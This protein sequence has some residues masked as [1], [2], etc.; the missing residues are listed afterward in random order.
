MEGVRIR[1]KEIEERHCKVGLAAAAAGFG[2][3]AMLF[4]CR[5]VSQHDR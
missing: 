3:L 1:N 4:R 2:G 5:R